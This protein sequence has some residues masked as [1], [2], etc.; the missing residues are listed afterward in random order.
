MT[1]QARDHVNR[2]LS[3]SDRAPA[4]LSGLLGQFFTETFEYDGERQVTVY[5][6]PDLPKQL[7]SPAMVS[8]SRSGV[9][10]SRR[11]TYHLR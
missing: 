6:P 9:G 7:S 2:E 3:A 11:P 10:C 1:K 8:E 4:K 5:V